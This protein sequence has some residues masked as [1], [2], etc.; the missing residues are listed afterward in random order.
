VH[1]LI[2][3]GIT[4]IGSSP[5]IPDCFPLFN[6]LRY[7]LRFCFRYACSRTSQRAGIPAG[8][9]F[10]GPF[11][12][13]NRGEGGVACHLPGA[14]TSALLKHSQACSCTVEVVAGSRRGL[15]KLCCSFSSWRCLPAA[16]LNLL[17]F[18]WLL[19]SA[20]PL[21]SP[22][23]CNPAAATSPGI[24]PGCA[25]ASTVGWEMRTSAS[26]ASWGACSMEVLPWQ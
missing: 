21:A 15:W 11:W 3:Q 16:P 5:T 4:V 2:S 19:G 17:F 7:V 23:C 22:R 18:T 9:C 10:P 25:W 12:E 26:T 20:P 14:A 13:Q 1:N 8:L 24:P 6:G